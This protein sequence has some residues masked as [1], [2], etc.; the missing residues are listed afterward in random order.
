MKTEMENRALAPYALVCAASKG[1]EYPEPSHPFR[2]IFERDR[3]RVVHSTAFRRLVNKTQVIPSPTNDHHRT[4][5]THTLEVAQI[6]RVVARQ[7]HLEEDLTESIALAHD[8]GHPPFGHAGEDELRNLMKDHGG[9]EHNLHALRIVT[10]LEYRYPGFPGLN[11]SWE[12]RE[13]FAH[14][15]KA[16]SNVFNQY[17]AEGKPFL[18]AQVAD[19]VDSLAYTSH[20]IEDAITAGLISNDEVMEVSLW[21]KS[22]EEIIEKYPF[23]P[24]GTLIPATVRN[25]I[26]RQVTDLL[27]QTRQN[28]ESAKIDSVQ[29]VRKNPTLIV[30]MSPDMRSSRLELERFLHRQVYQHTR[31]QRMAHKGKRILKRMFEEFLSCP[32]LLPSR[33]RERLSRSNIHQVVCDYVAGMT[34][35]FAR[36]EF[37]RLFDTHGDD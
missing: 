15:S 25:L 5:M 1:R 10:E 24:S 18:E 29:S 13:A 8:L 35:R 33:Y 30:A 31:V 6:S 2:T 21:R 16:K 11:L 20:D 7:L 3:D 22:Q 19:E 27:I 37:A 34:D 23:L 26:D 32:K 17:L 36:I 14:H 9:F 28:L 12:V 4:R